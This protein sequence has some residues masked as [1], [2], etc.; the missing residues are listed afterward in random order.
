MPGD[1]ESDAALLERLWRV[2]VATWSLYATRAGGRIIEESG[3]AYLIG[4]DPTPVIVNSVFR[5]A[6]GVG[7]EHL[8][9]R[10]RELYGSIGHDFSLVTN[11]HADSDLV[12][13]ALASGWSRVLSLPAMV[14]S[15]RLEER[16]LPPGCSIRRADPIRDIDAVRVLARDGFASDDDERAAANNVFAKP[17]A[18]G[19][20][21]TRAA[22]ASVDGQDVA[23]A[24]V[25]VIDGMGYVGWVGTLPT[26]RRQGLGEA[27]TRFVT[28]AAFD[29][30]ADV[31]AL[32]AS[33]M[34][35]PLYERMGFE[36]VGIDAIWAP[37][38]NDRAP[39]SSE[40]DPARRA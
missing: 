21:T 15:S 33:P 39:G 29:L 7:P 30:G 10:S 3:V 6:A 11:D 27:V 32:E 28:N 22:I 36:T 40:D 18:L 38:T 8:L 13:A 16:G 1:L 31:V 14:C 35:L 17:R 19:D 12:A 2:T 4:S 25:D 23:T 37:P 20:T 34:G 24:I 26:Y 5:V 9:R